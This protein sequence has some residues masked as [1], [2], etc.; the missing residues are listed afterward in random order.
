MLIALISVLLFYPI[1]YLVNLVQFFAF[2]PNEEFE[3]AL[4]FISTHLLKGIRNMGLIPCLMMIDNEDYYLGLG[5][6]RQ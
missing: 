1:L 5:K 4:W 3:E 6:L 2:V